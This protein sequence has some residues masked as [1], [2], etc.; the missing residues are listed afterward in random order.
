MSLTPDDIQAKRFHD[1]FRGYNHEEVDVF[2]DEVA[3][4]FDAVMK[5]VQAA[6]ARAD[7]FEAQVLELKGT[8]GMLKRTL[9][10]AQRASDEAIAEFI[11]R[12]V[13]WQ[14]VV[15]GK[16]PLLAKD[17]RNGAPE[18]KAVR[19]WIADPTEAQYLETSTAHLVEI[20]AAEKLLLMDGEWGEATPGLMEQAERFEEARRI[21]VEELEKKH[22]YER[23]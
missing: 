20:G 19:V 8:E 14:T 10:A 21:S 3:A 4:A 5:E 9:L 15:A 12:K 22:A 23:G 7:E 1:A 18:S 16:A 17:A 13:Y 6:R 2:L 11:R